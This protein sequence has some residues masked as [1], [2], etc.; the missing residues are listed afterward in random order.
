[1]PR[2]RHSTG[3][4]SRQNPLHRKTYFHTLYLLPAEKYTPG[5]N[6]SGLEGADAICQSTAA[7]VSLAGT[8][9]AILTDGNTDAVDRIKIDMPVLNIEGD[10]L[11]SANIF[12]SKDHL[13]PILYNERGEIQPPGQAMAWTGSNNDGRKKGE[14]HCNNWTILLLLAKATMVAR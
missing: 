1:M 2:F 12:W 7:S 4:N 9:K 10:L 6:F 5:V 8:Y 3:D 11:A 14:E 13:A